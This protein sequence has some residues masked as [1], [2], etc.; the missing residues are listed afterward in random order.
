M[1]RIVFII[2]LFFLD[3]T[4]G[5]YA[6]PLS[7]SAE[8]WSEVLPYLLPEDH[9]TKKTLDKI[10]LK[11]CLKDGVELYKAG[12]RFQ[13]NSNPHKVIVA[14]HPN[15]K[16]HLVKLFLDNQPSGI[17][18]PYWIKRI[19]GSNLIRETISE[20]DYTA[21][22]K[23]PHKWIY[24]LPCKHNEN[25]GRQFILVT[26]NKNLV[27]EY[28]NR[29]RWKNGVTYEQLYMFWDLL[30]TCGLFDSIYISNI[31]YCKDGRF[32]F[33]DTE[34]FLKWPINYKIFNRNL[35]SGKLNFWKELTS[36]VKSK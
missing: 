24:F 31:P 20:K 33:V 11:N 18:W 23:V 21:S 25:F 8:V 36:Q 1:I 5:T 22:F 28:D 16:E 7:V 10:F 27:S 4:E 30:E 14:I 34:H 17:E 35:R 2:F 32:A 19:E 29:S 13:N 9:P 6:K 12:F 3:I 26:E 15:L